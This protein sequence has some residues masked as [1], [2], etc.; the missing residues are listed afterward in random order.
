M[1]VAHYGYRLLKAFNWIP[2]LHKECCYLL[3]RL[4]LQVELTANSLLRDGA[5]GRPRQHPWQ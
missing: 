1:R 4:S 5:Q 2:Y 3:S